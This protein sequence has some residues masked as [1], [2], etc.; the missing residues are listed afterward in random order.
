MDSALTYLDAASHHFGQVLLTAAL[1]TV[2]DEV[3]IL[4][5]LDRERTDEQLDVNG[6]NVIKTW[7][8]VAE[9]KGISEIPNI[10]RNF[11]VIV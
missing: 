8:N 5:H 1:Q 7:L 3:S 9:V 10:L 6:T 11:S 2:K 4:F